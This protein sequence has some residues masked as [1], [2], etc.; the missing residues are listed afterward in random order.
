MRERVSEEGGDSP[1]AAH[2]AGS[3]LAEGLCQVPQ[4]HGDQPFH[5][6]MDAT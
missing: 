2:S 6:G 1:H 5:V 3:G 4:G